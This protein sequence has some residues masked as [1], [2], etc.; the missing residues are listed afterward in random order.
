MFR[1]LIAFGFVALTVVGQPTELICDNMTDIIGPPLYNYADSPSLVQPT[2]NFV[3]ERIAEQL[4]GLSVEE[5]AVRFPEIFLGLGYYLYVNGSQIPGYYG[6]FITPVLFQGF[7]EQPNGMEIMTKV[8]EDLSIAAQLLTFVSYFNE[9]C[10]ED[11]ALT[12]TI[13][14]TD[15]VDYMLRDPFRDSMSSILNTT[16]VV[17]AKDRQAEDFVINLLDP[18]VVALEAAEDAA[19]AFSTQ[20]SVTST[21]VVSSTLASLLISQGIE[22]DQEAMSGII[23]GFF[24]RLRTSLAIDDDDFVVYL[25]DLFN[26]VLDALK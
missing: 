13:L 11:P 12:I 14:A 15:V 7:Y 1:L 9:S 8:A 2:Q 24:E 21:D 5:A 16:F 4:E 20:V 23:S 17:V 25:L 19:G 3:S 10:M 22:T 6:G 26:N 18:L